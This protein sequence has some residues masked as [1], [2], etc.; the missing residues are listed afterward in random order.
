MTNIKAK[1]FDNAEQLREHL[2]ELDDEAPA[3]D[4]AVEEEGIDPRD[5]IAALRKEIAE[6]HQQLASTWGNSDGV[7]APTDTD[8]PWRQIAVTVA[9]TYIFGRL[10]QKLRL[11]AAGAAAVPLVASQLGRRF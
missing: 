5:Q 2:A 11:G 3:D 7:S 10:V 1:G 4:P 9:A 6:L 8:K